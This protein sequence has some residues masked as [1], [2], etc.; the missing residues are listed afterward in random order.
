MRRVLVLA[1]FAVPPGAAGGTRHVELFARLRGWRGRILAADW[2]YGAGRRKVR[3][4]E[5]QVEFRTVRVTG[6]RGN[7]LGRVVNWL[8]FLVSAATRGVVG[9]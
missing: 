7:N 6:Y 9:P 8:T 1:Q 2:A 3:V 4:A 5:G